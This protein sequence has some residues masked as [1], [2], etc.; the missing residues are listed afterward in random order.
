M[1]WNNLTKEE[2]ARYMELQMA[3][4]ARR[5]SAYLPDDSSE[6]GGCGNPTLGGGLCHDCYLEWKKLY[7]KLT[8]ALR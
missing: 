7:D 4:R 2:R 1:N 6:C 8:E 5:G 3:P